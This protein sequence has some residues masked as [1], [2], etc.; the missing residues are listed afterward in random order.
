MIECSTRTTPDGLGKFSRAVLSL[1]RL[2]LSVGWALRYHPD[3]KLLFWK[4]KDVG[5]GTAC[6]IH[7]LR[8]RLGFCLLRKERP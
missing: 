5:Y 4:C 6:E 8:L 2:V 3:T 1:G 7:A